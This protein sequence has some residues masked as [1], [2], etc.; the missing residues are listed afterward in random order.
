M[1][2]G[3]RGFAARF[4]CAPQLPIRSRQRVSPAMQSAL[5][6]AVWVRLTSGAGGDVR[7]ETSRMIL[8]LIA[9][10]N[11]DLSRAGTMKAP[12]PP[13]TQSRK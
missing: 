10:W 1:R 4:G 11:C 8:V 6:A 12:G 3:G 9:C 13:M 2:S 5:A 7:P